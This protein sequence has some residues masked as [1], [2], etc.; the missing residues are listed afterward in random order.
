MPT[1]AI[2]PIISLDATVWSCVVNDFGANRAHNFSAIFANQ[3]G[4]GFRTSLKCCGSGHSRRH[5]VPH[6]DRS[7]KDSPDKPAM[8]GFRPIFWESPPKINGCAVAGK[9]GSRK[10][11]G[12]LLL[13]PG[14][15]AGSTVYRRWPCWRARLRF[16]PNLRSPR[17]SRR[18]VHPSP[19]CRS[20]RCRSRATC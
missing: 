9:S 20:N 4:A 8:A 5:D 7:S 17:C 18:S 11:C 14:D 2:L 16:P 12:P 1:I 19:T 15:R 13:F 3:R 10:K 6:S